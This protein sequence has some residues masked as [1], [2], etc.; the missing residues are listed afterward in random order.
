MYINLAYHFHTASHRIPCYTH[1]GACCHVLYTVIG[2][3]GANGV[4]VQYREEDVE[5][6]L[7]RI[8]GQKQINTIQ[9]LSHTCTIMDNQLS[10][11]QPPFE[12]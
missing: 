6:V 2:G 5:E 7:L 9:G 3:N 11:P 8:L 10:F 12:H 1:I 4:L